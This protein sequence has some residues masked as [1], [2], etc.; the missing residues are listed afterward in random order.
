MVKRYGEPE[1]MEDF[2][3]KMQLMNAIGYQGIFEAA[4]HKL[5]DIGGVMLWKLNAAFP[6]VVWQVYDWYLMPNAGY[7]FMQNAVEPLHVQ[8]NIVSNKVLALNRTYTNVPGL[9]VVADVYDINSKSLFHEEKS[10]DLSETEA[11]ETSDL[12]A[13]LKGSQG[14]KFVVLRLRDS[15]GKTISSNT[16]WLS[17]DNDYRQMNSMEKTRV[18]TKVTLAA[19][20]GI[21]KSW[22]VQVTNSSNKLAFFIRPQL[23]T[24]EEEVLPTL[25]SAGYFTLAPSESKTITVT[26]PVAALKGKDAEVK[27]SGW[28]LE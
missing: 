22:T 15:G 11:E 24:G 6:S 2:S 8:L 1:S 16:Y 3:D 21:N 20:N 9:K 17:A 10:V 23:M 25:W 14:V 27:I 4:G 7:Y 18:E 28:N 26:C 12:S 19:G 13:V 5:N